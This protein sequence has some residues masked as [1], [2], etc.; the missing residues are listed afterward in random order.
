LLALSLRGAGEDQPFNHK[1]HAPLKLQCVSC[2][3]NAGQA[4]RAGFPGVAQ[5]R[6]CHVDMAE[7]K[8]PLQVVHELPDFVFFSHGKHAAAKVE[9]ASCHGNVAA[10]EIVTVRQALKM[11]WCVDCHKQ[12][13]AALRCNACH[14]LG[15]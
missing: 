1:K 4:D 10:Q 6:T 13:Q 11:K 9:C 3:K 5:C 2:H 8:I 15:Q 12:N 7:R 14:E